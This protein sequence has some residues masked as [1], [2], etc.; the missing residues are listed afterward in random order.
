MK[1]SILGYG[2]IG[3]P[4]ALLLVR[5]NHHVVVG[6]RHPEELEDLAREKGPKLEAMD[7]DRAIPASDVIIDALPFK[8]SMELSPD[9]LEGKMLISASNYVPHRDGQIVLGKMTDTQLLADRLEKT[10]VVK[11]FNVINA[12]EFEYNLAHRD[13]MSGLAVPVAGDH[14]PSVETAMT[15]VR[16]AGFHPLNFGELHMARFFTT[17][18]PVYRTGWKAP[19]MQ[20][21]LEAQIG[22]SV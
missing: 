16:D 20:E 18:T 13:D 4:L 5:M 2:K 7:P 9:A 10:H 1:V 15:L 17:G 11:A 22:R 8:N 21:W 14:K 3:R 12:Q 6:T 19:K